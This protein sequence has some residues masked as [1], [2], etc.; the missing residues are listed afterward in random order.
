MTALAFVLLGLAN[1]FVG[2]PIRAGWHPLNILNIFAGIAA[3]GVAYSLRKH[4]VT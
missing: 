1:I 2:L 3:L 4:R